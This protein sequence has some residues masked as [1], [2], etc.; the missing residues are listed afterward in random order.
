MILGEKPIGE[1]IRQWRTNLGM[2]MAD[3][4]RGAGI[5]PGMWGRIEKGE[6]L[7]PMWGTVVRMFWSMGASIDVTMKPRDSKPVQETL[8]IEAPK[9][10]PP[11]NRIHADG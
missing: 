8:P 4:A 11:R 10:K 6:T 3:A 7:A 9:P 1:E 2:T 5:H